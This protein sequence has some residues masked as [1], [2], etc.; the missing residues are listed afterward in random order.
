MTRLLTGALAAITPFVIAIGAS[1]LADAQA[2]E[3]DLLETFGV[4]AASTVTNTPL[5]DTI[6]DGN[7]G[8]Y[9]G[10]AIT[11]FS[12]PTSCAS[13][14]AGQVLPPSVC[15]LGDAV[16]KNAQNDWSIA[17]GALA[18]SPATA[19]LTG[20][21][22]GGKRL[23][24]GVYNFGSSAQLTGTLTLD[25]QGNPNALFIFK[26]KSTL[27]TASGSTVKLINGAQ[28]RNVFFQVG[29]SATLGTTTQFAGDILA[30]TSITLQTDANINCGAALA[31]T[32]AVT[33][34]D[35]EITI[36]RLKK[37]TVGSVVESK[38]TEAN[39][40]AVAAA[41]D[42]FVAH[43]GTLPPEFQELIG[44]LSPA[45]LAA[46]L[47]QLS[48]E[49]GS[50]VAPAGTQAMNSFMSL[51]FHRFE[52]DFGESP[53]TPRTD[54]VKTLD[55]GPDD[56][57][58]SKA[59]SAFAS[60]DTPDPSLWNSW[61]AAYGGESQNPGDLEAG[62]HDRFAS[63]FGIAG[64]LDYRVTP[65]TMVGFALSGGATDFHL[66][67]NLGSGHG[68]LLQ[69]AVYSR[70]KFGPAD[71]AYVATAL[72]YGRDSVSTDRLVT[73]LGVDEL[74]AKFSAQDFAGQVEGGYRF[75][76]PNIPGLPGDGWFIPY[77]AL[78]GQAFSTPA[79]KE[80]AVSGSSAFALAYQA[81]TTTTARSE[82]GTRIERAVPV[83]GEVLLLDTR[84][85]WA[86]YYGSNPAITAMFQALP[87]SIF[88][89]NGAATATDSVLVSAGAE[90]RFN[91]AFSIATSF[92]GEF[93]DG[94]QDYGGSVWLRHT[95]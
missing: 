6:I 82:L 53:G 86:H 10:T 58:A 71:A 57:Q 52:N 69:A 60:F 28:G 85:A 22:L 34:D 55:Y 87:G 23:K 41:L 92:D 61:A 21:D 80:S 29:S 95:W 12:F 35:N 30:L 7:L 45:Q 37:A 16:A 94:S 75:R 93:A 15:H 76:A 18:S 9:A 5:S 27:T 19:D 32:G 43:G 31:H 59:R 89:V 42:S 90:M 3:P 54:T 77:A 17:Y 4:L 88:T 84:V 67:D 50:A 74:T 40:L 78:R 62:T 26:I 47:T 83:D 38:S 72:A 56:P 25:G 48:G 73:V 33:L 36:C 66:S 1:T 2:I 14:G 13:G 39:E 81:Q 63:V 20:K 24:A 44:L 65:E 11:G 64:G 8:L 51:V 79:Y 46:A 91:R 68:N 49:V 70:T